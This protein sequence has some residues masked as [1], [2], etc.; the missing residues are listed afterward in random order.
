M[1]VTSGITKIAL[2][3][4]IS[5]VVGFILAVVV[6]N[7]VLAV[8]QL[9]TKMGWANVAGVNRG[10][11]FGQ[12][13][14]SAAMSLGH[15]ANDSQKTMGIIAAVLFLNSHAGQPLGEEL[16]IPLWVVL[17]AYTAMALGTLAGGWRIVRTLGSKLTKLQPVGGFAAET[18]AAATLFTTAHLGIPV[19]TT[20]TITGGVVGVGTTNRFS[21]VRWG[22]TGRVIWAWVLTIPGAGIIAALTWL[23]LQVV[24]PEIMGGITMIALLLWGASALYR[25]QAARREAEVVMAPPQ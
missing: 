12:L 15:G 22:L 23:V 11:R 2:F 6:E 3:I 5:P 14:S 16:T 20:H 13:L 10:M 4:L 18:A 1:L 8:C 9:F 25:K 19:S 7:V 17:S 21:A 24:S